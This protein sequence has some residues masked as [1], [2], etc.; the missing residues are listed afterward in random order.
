MFPF[1]LLQSVNTEFLLMNTHRVLDRSSKCATVRYRKNHVFYGFTI[2]L[3]S[4]LLLLTKKLVTKF[5][6]GFVVTL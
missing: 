1:H 3:Q 2:N 4:K 5:K 6:K